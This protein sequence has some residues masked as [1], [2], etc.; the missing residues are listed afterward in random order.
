MIADTGIAMAGLV[1]FPLVFA[2]GLNPGEGPDLV[3]KTLPLVFGQMQVG[4]FWRQ[5]SLLLSSLLL[6]LLV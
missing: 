5:F 1:I 6:L 4:T 3:F 2:N